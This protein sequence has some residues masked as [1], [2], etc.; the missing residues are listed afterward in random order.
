MMRD[1][2]RRPKAALASA[3]RP[4][5]PTAFAAPLDVC[6]ASPNDALRALRT[7]SNGLSTSEAAR[8]LGEFRPNDFERL[9]RPSPALALLSEFTHFFALTLWVTA[10]LAFGAALAQPC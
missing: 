5:P 1:S 10:G 6:H 3:S 2:A 9:D 8:R 7:T 4:T